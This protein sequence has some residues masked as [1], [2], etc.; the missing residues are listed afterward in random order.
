[1]IAW[2]GGLEGIQRTTDT[3]RISIASIVVRWEWQDTIGEIRERL[4]NGF[5]WDTGVQATE[6]TKPQLQI[7]Y[8]FGLFSLP[9]GIFF[10]FN[11]CSQKWQHLFCWATWIEANLHK[12][13]GVDR[14]CWQWGGE[15]GR[16]GHNI[17]FPIIHP[18]PGQPVAWVSQGIQGGWTAPL[19]S[20][21][22]PWDHVPALPGLWP[23]TV[24]KK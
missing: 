13:I 17:R 14:Q 12:H 10:F 16:M 19:G 18:E 21:E 7:N 5:T 24:Y 4:R 6:Q 3:W 20:L 23:R 2:G 22:P 9:L 8:L 11:N 1:M 15:E